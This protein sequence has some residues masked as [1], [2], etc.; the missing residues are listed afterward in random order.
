MLDEKWVMERLEEKIAEV[1]SQNKVG[2]MVG[3]SSAILSQLRAGKYTGDQEK[4][5]RKLAA[6]FKTKDVA[7]ETYQADAYVPTS[8][9]ESVYAV[10]KTICAF[11]GEEGVKKCI[12]INY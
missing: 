9:S 12:K 2:S 3:I 7:L 4:Q 6:Y 11:G 10:I 8:I 5:Y 1:G